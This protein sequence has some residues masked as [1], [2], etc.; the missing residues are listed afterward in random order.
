[1][2]QLFRTA[3]ALLFCLIALPAPAPDFKMADGSV[4]TGELVAPN[5]DGTVIR[6]ASGGLTGRLSWD[7]FAQETLLE[8]VADPRL[9]E[10]VEAFIDHPEPAQSVVP[11]VVVRPPPGK[12]HRPD[13]RPGFFSALATPAGWFILLVLF[14]A[15]LYAAY[16]IAVFRNYPAAAVMGTSVILP[17]L[18]PLLFLCM[19]T[20]VLH[21]APTPMGQF[22]APQEVETTGRQELAAAG[23]A[24]SALSLSASK[25]SSPSQGAQAAVYRG[26]EV[27]FNRSFFERTFPLFFR[28]TRSDSDKDAVLAV[29]SS[30]GEVVAIRISRISANEIGLVTQKGNEVQL[31]FGEISEVH[32]RPKSS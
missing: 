17:W 10:L 16:E 20:R 12:L 14:G 27:E 25:A 23:L 31:R 9:R 30:K 18:G 8:M 15:N 26:S 32:V 1:M 2:R 19:P 29:K 4:I 21:D 6:R 5:E 22:E 7:L 3:L 24:G 13:R 11:E 28:L